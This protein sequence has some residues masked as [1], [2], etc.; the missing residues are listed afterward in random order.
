M[1]NLKITLS[2]DGTFYYGF[3]YQPGLP[4]VQGVLES[5]W[6]QALGHPVG[7]V[8]AGRTDTGVHA[9]GQV[10]SFYTPVPWP[11]SSLQGALSQNLPQDI[12]V[13]SVSEVPLTFHAR[14]SARARCYRYRLFPSRIPSP[15]WR[16]RSCLVSPHI[17]ISRLQEFLLH[18]QGQHNFYAF[19]GGGI[20][21]DL[22]V[23][24]LQRAEVFPE[25]PFL[26]LQF[27]APSFLPRMIRMLVMAAIE[28]ATD[29][30][31]AES[32]LS[33]LHAPTSKWTKVA[34]PW[35]L[36]LYSVSYPQDGV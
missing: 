28:V 31:P 8:A 21:R 11:L 2:Y 35:G 13:V 6:K 22:T 36:S 16:Y 26:I 7:L 34:P 10:V 24:T 14:F 27:E 12:S 1:R 33:L 18:L 19:C 32:V 30:L 3:Q 15:L 4:T 29:S 5:C 9:E 25:G 23:R 20:P 17:S